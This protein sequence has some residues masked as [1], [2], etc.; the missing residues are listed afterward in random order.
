MAAL[1]E[2]ARR[3]RRLASQRRNVLIAYC[4]VAIIATIQTYWLRPITTFRIYQGS[5]S[6]LLELKDLYALDPATRLDYFKYSPTFAFLMLPFVHVPHFV[7]L[8]IWNLMNA[9]ALFTA[10]YGLGLADG[11]KALICWVTL[12]ELLTSIQHQ[13]SN[14][15]MAGLLVWTFVGLERGRAFWAAVPL[16][17]SVF[18]KLFGV[19]AVVLVPFYPRKMGMLGWCA[20]WGVLLFVLPCLVIPFDHL[21]DLYRRWVN[22]LRMD[23]AHSRG[24]S[25]MGILH[26]WFR[27]DL[28]A[29][30]VL[31]PAG[32][33]L[34][35][36]LVRSRQYGSA[37]YRYL[38]F[39]SL[40]VWLVIFNPKAESA[41]FVIALVGIAIWFAVSKAKPLDVVLLM[42]ALL[43][44]SFNADL[45]PKYFRRQYVGPYLLKAVPCVLI[46]LRM[47]QGLLLGDWVPAMA[48]RGGGSAGQADG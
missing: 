1:R 21:V 42:L 44:T 20:L 34:C 27:W 35:L 25:V 8:L 39:S 33:L 10:I 40:M 5:A 7:G 16:V 41:T 24:L 29:A 4:L 48:S 13:Q 31:L 36:P 15:L 22:L 45:F 18:L 43:L 26:A 2:I 38:Y 19:M 28:A 46:W 11:K 37:Q 14:G 6:H 17:L 12:W 9:L 23:L 30:A 3:C 47:Q 32:V